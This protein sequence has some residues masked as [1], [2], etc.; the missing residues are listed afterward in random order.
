M[1]EDVCD[2]LHDIPDALEEISQFRSINRWSAD[3]LRCGNKIYTALFTVFEEIIKQLLQNLLKKYTKAVWKRE[4][5]GKNLR[6]EVQDLQKCIEAFRWAAAYCDS[7]KIEFTAQS[8]VQVQAQ[9]KEYTKATRQSMSD[10]EHLHSAVAGTRSDNMSMPSVSYLMELE[11]RLASTIQGTM[12]VQYQYLANMVNQNILQFLESS[13]LYD[14][15]T[16]TVDPHAVQR[17][18]H[19]ERDPPTYQTP[20]RSTGLSLDHYEQHRLSQ[21]QGRYPSDQE[22]LDTWQM[23]LNGSSQARNQDAATSARWLARADLKQQDETPRDAEETISCALS[24]LTQS[25]SGYTSFPVIAYFCTSLTIRGRNQP[26]AANSMVNSLTGQL[27]TF[28]QKQGTQLD[29]TAFR[30]SRFSAAHADLLSAMELFQGILK[31]LPSGFTLFIIIDSL[32]SLEYAGGQDAAIALEEILEMTT[33]T[34]V[35][36]KILLCQPLRFRISNQH[37]G[38]CDEL[39]LPDYVDGDRNGFN[40]GFT[41]METAKLMRADQ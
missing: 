8:V 29:V 40:V 1:R 20:A 3:L 37:K 24:L 7:K 31:Q 6:S 34:G 35:I 36:I 15:G 25:L 12:T 9:L 19:E 28:L 4:D 10:L 23:E 26:G 2:T 32:S 11:N 39:H 5:Y 38:R 13:S 22:I 41:H 16:G 30:N 17:K 33:R 18:L 21:R 27:L 14:R